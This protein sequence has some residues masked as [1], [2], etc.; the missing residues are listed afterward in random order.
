MNPC[1]TRK[2]T[3]ALFITHANILTLSSTKNPDI[4]EIS[5]HWIILCV[6]S[7]ELAITLHLHFV[8]YHKLCNTQVDFCSHLFVTE[9]LAAF[10]DYSVSQ[11]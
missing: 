1:R 11:G 3:S 2:K 6:R 5:Q 4:P 7:V 9:T 10:S 8:K